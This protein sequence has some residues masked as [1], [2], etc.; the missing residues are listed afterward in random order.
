MGAGAGCEPVTHPD[1]TR[2]VHTAG[3]P[4][5]C[6]LRLQIKLVLQKLAS[7]N[8]T[9]IIALNEAAELLCKHLSVTYCRCVA[10]VLFSPRCA[11]QRGTQRAS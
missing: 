5:V 1:A 11:A 3:S 2:S 4:V 8:S 7:V 6:V 10:A 9:P